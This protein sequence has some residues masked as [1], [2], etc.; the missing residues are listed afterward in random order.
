MTC[1]VSSGTLNSTNSTHINHIAL[2]TLVLICLV[3]LKLV[4]IIARRV[5]KLPTN[6]GI[7]TTFH[8]R[9]M[10]QHV[11]CTTWHC[12]LW[13]CR[14]SPCRGAC[15]LSL[16][17]KFEVH[18]PS[19][20]TALIGL[21][22]WPLNRF[23]GYLGTRQPDGHSFCTVPSYGGREHDNTFLHHGIIHSIH[24]WLLSN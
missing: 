21:D 3:T 23:M 1:Y 4:Q 17:T 22:L 5:G 19:L 18:R 16:C 14:S 20:V 2:A 7:H 10:S 12:D 24:W 13:P 8:S 6:F 15:H 11:R 9:L